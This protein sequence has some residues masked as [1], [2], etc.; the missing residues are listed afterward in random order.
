LS[1]SD[2]K[3]ANVL[4]DTDKN[5]FAFCVLTDFG[6]TQVLSMN[7][8]VNGFN[9]ANIRGLSFAYASPETFKRQRAKTV[10]SDSA[11]TFKAGDVYSWASI[12]YEMFSRRTPWS[13][14]K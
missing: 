3:S 11:E 2:I 7:L 10:F 5:G 12:L 1:H 4:I 14:F 13:K 9:V 6:I 8:V